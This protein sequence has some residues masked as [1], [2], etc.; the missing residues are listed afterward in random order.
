[1]SGQQVSSSL[2]CRSCKN[3]QLRGKIGNP[4]FASQAGPESDPVGA[5]W[6]DAGKE[7]ASGER[8]PPRGRIRPR[9]LLL[10]VLR[11][12][13]LHLQAVRL[14]HPPRQQEAEAAATA[15]ATAA[16]LGSC[17]GGQRDQ[18]FRG[19]DDSW[20]GRA[21]K[22]SSDPATTAAAK[23]PAKSAAT[24]VP[25]RISAGSWKGEERT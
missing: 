6:L 21:H 25:G 3:E 11:L 18:L 23:I 19:V 10:L 24:G 14:H 16:E 15:K 8:P 7:T 9:S 13:A 12:P 20:Q 5:R 22:S 17:R 2:F 1:M 4:E